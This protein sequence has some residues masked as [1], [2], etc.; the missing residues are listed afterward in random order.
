M[1]LK[2]AVLCV[3]AACLCLFL[4]A[5]R[6]EMSLMVALAAGVCACILSLDELA[7]IVG[8]IK[9]VFHNASLPSEDMSI[10]L[11]AAGI[12][13]VGEYG[14]QLCRDAGEGAL[15]QRVDM[16]IRISL[17]ALA[18][19]LLLRAISVFSELGI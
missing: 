19:P 3:A 9:T 11:K 12:S 15:A 7:R 5:G 10:I 18:S 2:I 4:R 17:L 13:I 8:A 14:A 16:A 1:A 6:P